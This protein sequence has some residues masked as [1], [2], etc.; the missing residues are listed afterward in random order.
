MP[1]NR[2]LFSYSTLTVTL[3][4]QNK[5]YS[6]KHILIKRA[7]TAYEIIHSFFC[8]HFLLKHVEINYENKR[9]FVKAYISLLSIEILINSDVDY[10]NRDQT[11]SN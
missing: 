6:I 4:K 11:S 7:F 5:I 8:L 1:E 10:A 9:K 2:H 3:N